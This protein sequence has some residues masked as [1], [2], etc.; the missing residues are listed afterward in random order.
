MPQSLTVHTFPNPEYENEVKPTG[1]SGVEMVRD[2]EELDI[3]A[4]S[5]DVGE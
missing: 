4:L 2:D 5:G 1:L 3:V